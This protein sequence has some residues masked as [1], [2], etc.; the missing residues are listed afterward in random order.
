MSKNILSFGAHPDD[1]ELGCAATEA[2]LIKK[3]H[4]V[5]HGYVTSGEAGSQTISRND[6]RKTRESEARESAKV[7]GVKEVIF[8]RYPDGLTGFTEMMRIEI[9]NIIRKIRP[10]IIFVHETN[11]TFPD[12]KIVND[13][14]LS[15]VAGAAG[16]WFQET[17]GEPYSTP[18]ILGYEVW[19]PLNNF[20][21]AVDISDTI[22]LKMKA[23]S[24]YESQIGPTKYDEAFKGLA[25]YRGVMT[26]KGKYA[27][28]FE[29]IKSDNI[30]NK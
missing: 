9:I 16:P 26:W 6:L 29:V 1:I 22:D 5:I 7:L 27:E 15:A 13:L 21:F 14:V 8:L 19:H 24:C 10:E 2:S 12:H 23:L 11:E 20:Q 17:E 28:V 18:T 3:G 4:T 25:R 30:L